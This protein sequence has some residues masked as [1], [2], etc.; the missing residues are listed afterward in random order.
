MS[1]VLDYAWARPDPA[2]IKSKGYIGVLRYLAPLP[3]GKVI[4][5][6]E[7][8]E[9]QAAGLQ[10]AL[11]WESYGNRARE[12]TAA[13]LSDAKN[14]LEQAQ[15]LDYAGVIYFSVDYDAPESDQIRINQYFIACAG[16]IGRERLGAYGGY[17]PLKRLF[18]SGLI[19]FG[20]QTVAWSGSNRE[21]RCHLFQTGKHDFGE[22]AD[23]NDVLK[24]DWR[25]DSVT[26]DFRAQQAKDIWEAS[27]GIHAAW[28]SAWRGGIILGPPTSG[29]VHTV[30]WSGA[31]IVRQDFTQGWIE[32]YVQEA[33]GHPAGTD[34][35]YTMSG[36]T[37]IIL[38]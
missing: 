18:D 25:G 26:T 4:D 30:D 23:I 6:A 17:W 24:P 21:S 38:W 13:G 3:N 28:L 37:L 27:T 7:Y 19:S 10:I 36:K 22:D 20:W 12:G 34:H 15:A 16:V 8:K 2:Q 1:Q 29:E 32:Y 14:A 35:G 31:A 11:N 5:A 9:L 33:P